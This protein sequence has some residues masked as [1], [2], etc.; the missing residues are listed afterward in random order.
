LFLQK[1]VQVTRLFNTY[2]ELGHA[3]EH[4]ACDQ[5]RRGLSRA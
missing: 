4:D 1:K 2:I 3:C 5:K